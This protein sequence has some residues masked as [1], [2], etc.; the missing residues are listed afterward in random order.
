MRP[1]VV[2]T[3]TTTTPLVEEKKTEE[4]RPGKALTTGGDEMTPGEF[5]GKMTRQNDRE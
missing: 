5:T 4:D 2:K 3:C 1:G